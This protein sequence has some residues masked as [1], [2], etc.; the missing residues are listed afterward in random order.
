M[1]HLIAGE[2]DHERE[3]AQLLN[4]D[5]DDLTQRTLI[6]AME[7]MKY[8][9]MNVI[10]IRLP[11]FHVST[12]YFFPFIVPVDGTQKTRQTLRMFVDTD[13]DQGILRKISELGARLKSRELWRVFY[14]LFR[15]CVGLAYG[16][17]PTSIHSS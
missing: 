12:I 1:N 2:D 10:R 15:A 13:F 4:I 6:Y 17:S 14:C 11:Y 3:L 9:N 7:Y 5:L 16:T 8:G